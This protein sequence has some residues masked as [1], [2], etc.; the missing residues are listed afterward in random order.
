MTLIKESN[1]MSSSIVEKIEEL[2][3]NPGQF[4]PEN[5]GGMIQEMTQFFGDL[6]AK[7]TSSDVK[8][9]EEAQKIADELKAKLEEQVIKLCETLGMDPQVIAQYINTPSNFSPEEWQAMEKAKT[10]L[11]SYKESLMKMNSGE[12]V[13]RKRNKTK[14]KSVKEWIVG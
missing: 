7:L 14:P 9:R 10:E 8:D 13:P 2:F 5:M 3:K 12:A 11:E 1:H 4:T 6:K